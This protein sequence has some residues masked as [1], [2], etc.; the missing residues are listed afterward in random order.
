MNSTRRSSKKWKRMLVA[1]A[2]C[3]SVLTAS[4][5]ASGFDDGHALLEAAT[6]DETLLSANFVTYVRAVTDTLLFLQNT[7]G[8][9]GVA[10]L[11]ISFCFPEAFTYRDMADHIRL[12][13][14]RLDQPAMD[15]FFD[16]PAAMVVSSLFVASFL[17]PDDQ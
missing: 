13:L 11:Q 5:V 14:L 9:I 15:D 1:S 4:T 10:G 2:L 17:C 7:E 3:A 6:S 16:N 8:S 12:E